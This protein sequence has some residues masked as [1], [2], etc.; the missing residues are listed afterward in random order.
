[1]LVELQPR[2]GRTA[3]LLQQCTRRER[4]Q[5]G[6]GIAQ[7]LPHYWEC[8]NGDSC[9]LLIG[10]RHKTSTGGPNF[11]HNALVRAQLDTA[12]YVLFLAICGGG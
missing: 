9:R 3:I 6:T 10:H 4:P 11:H 8:V 12:V 1:M 2:M 7:L 5:P